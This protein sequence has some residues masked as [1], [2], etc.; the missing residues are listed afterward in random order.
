MS[1]RVNPRPLMSFCRLML[2]LVCHDKSWLVRYCAKK[3]PDTVCCAVIMKFTLGGFD[4][5]GPLQAALTSGAFSYSNP[6]TSHRL[7]PLLTNISVSAHEEMPYARSSESHH[8]DQE[9]PF[10]SRN[11]RSPWSRIASMK[12]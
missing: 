9:G 3:M 12:G 10:V 11:S 5:P 7:D 4:S 8:S 6:L 1:D 2:N